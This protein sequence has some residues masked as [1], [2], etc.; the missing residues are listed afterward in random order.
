MATITLDGNTKVTWVDAAD[1]I[2]DI[3]APTVAELG[4]GIDL[5]DSITP[6]GLSVTPSTGS[7]DNSNLGSTF[8]TN[9]V[10]RRS[11]AS[12]LKIQ[13]TS[14]AL[15]SDPIATALVYG[16]EGFLVIRKG[17]GKTNAYAA[18]QD[19]KVY[20]MACGEP[21]EPT[22]AAEQLWTYEVPMMVTDDPSTT[23]TVAA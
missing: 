19:V 8:N 7:I 16:A 3:N 17:L 21:S 13:R 11:F 10:G 15:A 4:A 2:V 20:P 23:A 22:S 6:D 9:Q 1:G 14:A 5:Q 12:S 18:S